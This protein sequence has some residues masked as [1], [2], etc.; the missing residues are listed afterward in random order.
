MDTPPNETAYVIKIR[1]LDTKPQIW[2]RFFVPGGI[3]LDRLHDVIQIVMG[4]QE[5][6]LHEFRIAGRKYTER[7]DESRDDELE[8]AGFK[9]C[10]LVQTE[11]GRFIYT[12]DFGDG[13]NHELL[14]EEIREVPKGHRACIGCL[15]GKR[16]CP[17]E[18]VGGVHGFA[19]FLKAIQDEKHEEHESYL[20][21]CGGSFDAGEFDVDLVNVDLAKFA[22]WSR[23]RRVVQQMLYSES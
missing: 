2:R 9:L 1:L 19:E 11:R 23:P 7:T 3:T 4:W 18:D 8:E 12:Y 6:H 5:C 17:P 14:V 15:D 21:W 13:W 10:D 20:E 22:R 16:R